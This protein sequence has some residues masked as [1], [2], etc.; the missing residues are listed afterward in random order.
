MA[1]SIPVGSRRPTGGE[2][3][4][5]E[6]VDAA[7][8]RP[9]RWSLVVLAALVAVLVVTGIALDARSDGSAEPARSPAEQSQLDAE[10]RFRSLAASA[11]GVAT[12]DPALAER[13]GS[14][15]ADLE[16]QADAVALP[17]VPGPEGPGQDSTPTSAGQPNAPSPTSSLTGAPSTAAPAPPTAPDV[18]QLLSESTLA[19]LL[20]AVDADPGPSRVLA[21]AGVNQWRHTALL[22]GALGVEPPLPPAGTFPAADLSAGTGVFA[23]VAASVPTTGQTGVPASTPEASGDGEPLG[24]CSGTPLGSDADRRALATVRLAEEEARYAYEVAAARLPDQRGLLERSAAH[25]EA[26]AEAGHRLA[27]L[28]VGAGP[29]AAGFALGAE[30]RENPSSALRGLEQE[31]LELYAGVVPSVSRDLRSWAIAALS[32]AVQRSAAMGIPVETFPGLPTPAPAST[33]GAPDDGTPTDG[34]TTDGGA[35]DG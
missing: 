13:L 8:G 11:R 15:A 16:A 32:T 18:L 21:S 17:Q 7:F 1:S 20:A 33:G 10:A 35:A 3:G 24:E 5:D 31:H 9:L 2:Q 27:T 22:A 29:A 30:F 4:S 25:A 6:P 23:R 12:T 19:S 14:L 34:T 28:C 26:A